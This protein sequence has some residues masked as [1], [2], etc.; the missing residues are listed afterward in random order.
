[1]A[2]VKELTMHSIFH[3][4]SETNTGNYVRSYMYTVLKDFSITYMKPC[5]ES[6]FN[7]D[8]EKKKQSLA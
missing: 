5:Y 3:L 1:M 2:V 6:N 7:T 4:T 8:N